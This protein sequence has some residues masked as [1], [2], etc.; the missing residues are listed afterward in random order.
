MKKKRLF[1]QLM[2]EG[3][4]T[5]ALA[6][7]GGIVCGGFLSEIISL[8]TA[9]LVGRGVIAHQPSFSLGAVVWTTLGFLLIQSV[10]L[11]ILGSRLFHREIYQLLYGEMDKK[12]NAGNARGGFLTLVPGSAALAVAYWIVLNGGRRRHAACRS[13]IGHCGNASFYPGPGKTG[14]PAGQLRKKQS[15]TR[16]L[17]VHSATVAGKHRTQVYLRWSGLYFDDV[18]HYTDS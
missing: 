1:L 2:G 15:D 7:C 9:R 4:I 13:P 16:S 12:Q 10:A 11:S 5:S 8:T 3:L 17:Y 14:K 18:Y 6:L